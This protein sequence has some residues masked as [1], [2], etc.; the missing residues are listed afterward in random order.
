MRLCRICADVFQMPDSEERFVRSF[1]GIRR[2]YDS[3]G[4]GMF[5]LCSNCRDVFRRVRERV[6]SFWNKSGQ[7]RHSRNIPLPR[8]S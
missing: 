4:R 3:R 1:P 2:I 5:E 8:E 7:L 6:G